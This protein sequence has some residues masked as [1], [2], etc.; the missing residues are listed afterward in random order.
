[1]ILQLLKQLL[2]FPKGLLGGLISATVMWTVVIFYHTWH[3]AR[4]A[5]RLG[6]E[7]RSPPLEAGNI[8]SKFFGLLCCSRLRLGWD[9]I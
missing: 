9:F 5:R 3:A 7:D 4:S 1:M 8:S 6:Y 2:I